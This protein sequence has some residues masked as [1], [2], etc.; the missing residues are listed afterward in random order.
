VSI[1]IAREATLL[2]STAPLDLAN[3]SRWTSTWCNS[4]TNLKDRPEQPSKD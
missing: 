3:R 4:W 1:D 2:T